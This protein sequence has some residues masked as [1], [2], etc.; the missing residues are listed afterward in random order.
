M[1]AETLSA[2]SLRFKK[3]EGI[4]SVIPA[5]DAFLQHQRMEIFEAHEAQG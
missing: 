5:S 4:R 3:V 2:M 1:S